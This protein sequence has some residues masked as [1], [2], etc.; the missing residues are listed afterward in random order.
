MVLVHADAVEAH[1]F[2]EFELIEILM[3]DAVP[4]FGLVHLARQIHPD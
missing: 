4:A 2:G 3:V 1:A